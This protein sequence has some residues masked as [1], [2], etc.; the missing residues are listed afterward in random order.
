MPWWVCPSI[1]ARSLGSPNDPVSAG[2]DFGRLELFIQSGPG[3]RTRQPG[4]K[5]QGASRVEFS[6]ESRPGDVVGVSR[7]RSFPG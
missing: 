7:Q 4:R 1:V 3:N 5:P 2:V 6:R